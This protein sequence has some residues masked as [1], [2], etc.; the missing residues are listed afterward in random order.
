MSSIVLL[1]RYKFV[2]KSTDIL[3]DLKEN[4]SPIV[5]F[6]QA[7]IPTLKS[8]HFNFGIGKVTNQSGVMLAVGLEHVRSAGPLD[9]RAHEDA[10]PMSTEKSK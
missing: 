8:K 2:A 9:G 10:V 4:H 3:E 5:P 1:C 6:V 7:F